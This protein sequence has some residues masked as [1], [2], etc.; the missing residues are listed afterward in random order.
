MEFQVLDGTAFNWDS[1]AVTIA[2]SSLALG[3]RI[4]WPSLTARARH[5]ALLSWTP[6][7]KLMTKMR[8]QSMR[9]QSIASILPCNFIGPQNQHQ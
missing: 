4:K 1:M 5:L 8:A 7:T 6:S 3:Q 2:W 9:E